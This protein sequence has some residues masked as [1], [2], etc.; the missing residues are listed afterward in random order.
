MGN[1]L[2]PLN[3]NQLF[4]KLERFIYNYVVV[5]SE[6]KDVKGLRGCCL[7]MYNSSYISFTYAIEFS[8][9]YKSDGVCKHD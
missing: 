4:L 1:S 7:I 8:F 6:K 5:T 2:N 9:T 3:L